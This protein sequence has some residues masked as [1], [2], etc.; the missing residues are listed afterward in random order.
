MILVVISTS[1]FS[2][3]LFILYDEIFSGSIFAQEMDENNTENAFILLNESTPIPSTR[4]TILTDEIL[5]LGEDINSLKNASQEG[6]FQSV[7]NKTFEVVSGPN[8]GNISADLLYRKE[9]TPL[10]NFVTNLQILNTLTK[11]TTQHN[12]AVNDSIIRESDTLVTNYGKVLDALAVPIFD[13]PKIIT[14][15]I[16]PVIIVIVIVLAIPK[17][18]K[19]YKIRY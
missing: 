19:R 8:W 14:N 17:I 18:R 11:N 7:H 3:S 5:A 13:I 1:G 9:L 12:K 2:L 6:D 10:N 15:L 4:E 16:I